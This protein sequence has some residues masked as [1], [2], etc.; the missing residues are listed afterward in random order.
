MQTMP[1]RVFTPAPPE[2]RYKTFPLRVILDGVTFYNLGYSLPP[3]AHKLGTKHGYKVSVSTL[4]KLDGR[5]PPVDHDTGACVSKESSP[6]RQPRPTASI[7]LH[8]TGK[9]TALLYHRPKIAMV[10]ESP[11]HR[12]FAPLADFIEQVP[13]DLPARPFSA[14]PPEHRSF[15]RL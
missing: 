9:S 2:L 7:K 12:R 14:T 3:A 10:R 15:R 4:A 6:Y 5:T 8:I 1:S 13:E 11:Q